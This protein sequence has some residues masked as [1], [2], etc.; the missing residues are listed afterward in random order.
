M[1]KNQYHHSRRS[2]LKLGALAPLG[3]AIP[4]IASK[5]PGLTK[6]NI[7]D[8]TVILFQGDSITDAGRDRSKNNPNDVR[9]L[10]TGYVYQIVAD[11][12]AHYPKDQVKCYNRGISG[13]KVF[14]LAD[15]WDDDCLQLQPDVLSILIGVNDFWHTLSSG[16]D[17]T[18]EVFKNDLITLL[19]RTR[20]QL[21]SVKIILG[22]PF[23]VTGGS[24]LTQEWQQSFPPYQ[25][26]VKEIAK[27]FDAAFIPYQKVFDQALEK[28][29]VSH[30]CPDGVHPSIAG[31]YLMK[32]A[33]VHAFKKLV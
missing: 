17:G 7:P 5:T 9:G 19:E 6:L 24:A 11:V 10:G 8:G 25:V 28:G 20:K 4:H 26:A 15:R 33:W 14:Q 31:A 27:K 2:L 13:N 1:I 16:Y 3:M 22:E 32:E 21:P 18:P 30:W 29:P 23:A 12:Q